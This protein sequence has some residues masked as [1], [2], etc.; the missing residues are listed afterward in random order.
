MSALATTF[1]DLT[2]GLTPRPV[3]TVADFFQA[4][5]RIRGSLD[6]LQVRWSPSMPL[7]DLHARIDRL[8][9]QDRSKARRGHWSFDPNRL[10][11]FRQIGES[12]DTFTHAED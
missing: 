8:I 1:A 10:I 2:V 5:P 11:A 9:E 12:I 6:L 3:L 4:Q 7:S